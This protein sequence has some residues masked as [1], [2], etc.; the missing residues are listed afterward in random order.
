MTATP[1]TTLICL[2][3]NM[4]LKGKGG[5]KPHRVLDPVPKALQYNI[6]C[7][8][9]RLFLVTPPC[10]HNA[11][12]SFYLDCLFPSDH[13]SSLNQSHLSVPQESEDGTGEPWVAHKSSYPAVSWPDPVFLSEKTETLIPL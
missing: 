8:H 7:K 9:N 12:T 2:T 11:P 3:L 6:F 13:N 1:V 4:K 10:D 5:R